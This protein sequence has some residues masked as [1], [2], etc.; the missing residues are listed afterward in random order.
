MTARR[1]TLRAVN[2]REIAPFEFGYEWVCA[3]GARLFVRSRTDRADGP[4]NY[5]HARQDSKRP[6]LKQQPSALTWAGLAAE[7]GWQTEPTVV[8]PAC[9]AGLSVTA[10]RAAR[11]ALGV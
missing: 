2:G 7:R 3:C 9:Q 4:N 8:C 1:D 6:E 5:D 11:R 10:Y